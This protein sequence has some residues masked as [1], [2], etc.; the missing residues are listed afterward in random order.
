M[1]ARAT[2]QPAALCLSLATVT[3]A[4]GDL[5]PGFSGDGVD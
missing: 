1:N 2:V 4:D 3:A 5:D